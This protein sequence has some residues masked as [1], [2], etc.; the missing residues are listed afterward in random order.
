MLAVAERHEADVPTARLT[1]TLFPCYLLTTDSDLTDNGFGRPDLLPLL[2][3]AANEGHLNY[4]HQ[5]VAVP[6]VL[7]QALVGGA[8]RG[9]GRLPT[10]A[11]TGLVIAGGFLV[12][13]WHHDGRL[14]GRLRQILSV[15]TDLANL[16]TPPLHQLH[17]RLSDAKAI[18]AEYLPYI[19]GTVEL[20]GQIARI[21]ASAPDHG[22]LTGDIARQLDVDGSVKSRTLAVREALY[23]CEA[24]TQVSRARW[25]LGRPATDLPR[26]LPPALTVDWLRRAHR[27]ASPSRTPGTPSSGREV[28]NDHA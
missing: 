27:P 23:T 17:Q 14:A 11:Q 3:A 18:W 7:G 25:R 9:F 22:V 19:S 5:A 8:V 21:L 28:P 26:Q 24:F 15:V 20:S 4:V 6:L 12:Y 10:I 13:Q 16:A 1:F 2:H